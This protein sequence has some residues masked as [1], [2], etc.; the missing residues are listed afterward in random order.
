MVEVADRQI[1]NY[2]WGMESVENSLR[3]VYRIDADDRISYVNPAWSD[4]ARANQGEAVM[5][6]R[7]LGSSLLESVGD[8]TVQQ[9]YSEMIK[10]AR[11]GKPV[12]F[13][14]RCDAPDRRRT[15]E[16]DIRQVD[17]GEVEFISALRHEEVR[18]A[19][20][21]LRAGAP[22]DNRLLR[23]CSWCQRVALPDATWVPVEVAVQRL[24]LLEAETFPSLTHGICEPCRAAWEK[25][26]AK[27]TG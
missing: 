16:M 21:V 26:M 10:R 20:A 1:R 18:P 17:N 15:F 22:R 8:S 2:S 13:K 9:L 14:Y 23:V 6:E 12:R 3:L 5:P 7:V 19:V 27:A 11:A 25:D 4:F 24:G